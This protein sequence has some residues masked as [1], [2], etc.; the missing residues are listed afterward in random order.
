[1]SYR[2]LR[3]VRRTVGAD[4]VNPDQILLTCFSVK[5]K[6]DNSFVTEADKSIC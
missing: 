4:R 1:M 6:A 3:N 2:L 5:T